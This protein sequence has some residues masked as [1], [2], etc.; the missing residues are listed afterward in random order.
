[1]YICADQNYGIY[2]EISE[3]YAVNTRDK[4]SHYGRK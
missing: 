1:M 2:I 3:H 4:I